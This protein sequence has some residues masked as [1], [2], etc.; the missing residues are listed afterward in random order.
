[1]HIE[2]N[3]S[4][5]LNDVMF[6]N[7]QTDIRAAS[8]VSVQGSEKNTDSFRLNFEPQKT[9]HAVIFALVRSFNIDRKKLSL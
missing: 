5:E 4:N 6:P 2:R 1:M 8:D 3:P 9:T 7:K